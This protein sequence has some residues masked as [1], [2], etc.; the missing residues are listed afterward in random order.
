MGSPDAISRFKN[1]S[2]GETF[3]TC[4]DSLSNVENSCKVTQ[5]VISIV[6]KELFLHVQK[7]IV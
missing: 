3:N 2:Q 5:R 7:Q 1:N 6:T 4:I